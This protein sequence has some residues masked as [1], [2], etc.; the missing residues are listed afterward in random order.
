MRVFANPVPK[1]CFARG[2]ARQDLANRWRVAAYALEGEDLSEARRA[3]AGNCP[4]ALWQQPVAFSRRPCDE[5]SIH[6]REK[7]ICISPP[8]TESCMA[9][10]RTS[11][12]SYPRLR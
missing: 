3:I 9:L 2:S 8:M 12:R 10:P 7:E 1:H 6:S 4:V 11:H 5:T